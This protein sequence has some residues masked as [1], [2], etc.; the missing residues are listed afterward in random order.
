MSSPDY[1]TYLS[2]L[3]PIQHAKGKPIPRRM[4]G[5]LAGEVGAEVSRTG[6]MYAAVELR[7]GLFD[8]YL[9]RLFR[10][11]RDPLK[12]G[13]AVELEWMKGSR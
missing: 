7:G 3:P 4:I 13:D 1:L 10:G 5:L 8:G 2:F 6:R 9:G 11:D 12:A